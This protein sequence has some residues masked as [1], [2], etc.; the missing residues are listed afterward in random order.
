M[1]M[2]D[3][4]F[5]EFQVARIREAAQKV[6]SQLRRIADD[7]ERISNAEN[8]VNIPSD[9]VHTVTWGVA[10]TNLSAPAMQLAEL[11]RYEQALTKISKEKIRDGVDTWEADGDD[12]ALVNNFI[13]PFLNGKQL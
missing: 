3:F 4:D 13:D 6:A 5:L 11:M 2:T 9:V 1:I 7:V 8:V 12:E 10:N